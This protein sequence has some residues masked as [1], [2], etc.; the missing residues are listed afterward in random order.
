M[1]PGYLVQRD[2]RQGYSRKMGRESRR[3][4]CNHICSICD[5]D[6]NFCSVIKTWILRIELIKN[7]NSIVTTRICVIFT[8]GMRNT[9]SFV[10][11]AKE[12]QK[13]HKPLGVM[14]SSAF[15]GWKQP[16][17]WSHINQVHGIR[18]TYSVTVRLSFH[19]LFSFSLTRNLIEIGTPEV[20]YS[21]DHT[22]N[23]SYP[24]LHFFF[25]YSNTFEQAQVILLSIEVL[26]IKMYTILVL[27]TRL[28]SV[29]VHYKNEE[30]IP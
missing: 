20:R 5:W 23:I 18:F 9:A 19:G 24:K 12:R 10:K 27:H 29:L 6:S 21:G 22:Q 13:L 7:P 28:F 26:G 17:D 15:D 16:L 1:R 2:D 14:Y 8:W 3:I 25:S 4:A 30:I 11:Q